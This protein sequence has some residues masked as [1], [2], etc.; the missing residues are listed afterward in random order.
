VNIVFDL[1]AVLFTWEPEQLVRTHLGAHAADAPAVTALARALFTHEDWLG[2][3]RGTHSLDDAIAR[4]AQRLS[5]PADRLSA[6][7]P[8]DAVHLRPIPV[9]IALLD[10]LRQRRDAGADLRLYY[11]SNM[12]APHARIL[13][14]DQP[15]IGWFDGGVFSGDV[16]LIKPQREIFELLASRYALDATVTVF[17]DDALHNVEAARALGWS[18]VHCTDPAQLAMQLAPWTARLDAPNAAR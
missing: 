15:A 18:A 1:G 11:L 6:M 16:K 3:D 5:L 10:D 9:T 7:M 2:F 14:R 17:I 4:M 12:P 8:A 13:E